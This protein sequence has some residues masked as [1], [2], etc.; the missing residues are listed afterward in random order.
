MIFLRKC[1]ACSLFL[2]G[3]SSSF[4]I[5]FFFCSHSN[6][7]KLVKNGMDTLIQFSSLFVRTLNRLIIPVGRIS[8]VSC[9]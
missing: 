8:L 3:A 1:F 9:I 7:E 4:K 5:E 2:F 6:Y